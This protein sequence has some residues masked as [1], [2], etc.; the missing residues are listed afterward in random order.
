MYHRQMLGHEGG[1]IYPPSSPSTHQENKITLLKG[2][3]PTTPLALFAVPTPPSLPPPLG[4]WSPVRL[5][6]PRSR[7]RARLTLLAPPAL[8]QDHAAATREGRGSRGSRRRELLQIAC[9]CY[10]S[11]SLLVLA[12]V[13][14]PPPSGELADLKR[15]CSDLIYFLFIRLCSSSY[16]R[17]SFRS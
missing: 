8:S 15:A 5:S 13:P 9:C 17:A 10:S 1:Y 16:N 3:Y 11:S 14:P 7:K 2:Y 4:D 6:R 12:P